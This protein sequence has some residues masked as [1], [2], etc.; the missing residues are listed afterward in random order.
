MTRFPVSCATNKIEQILRRD[1]IYLIKIV[2]Y[3]QIIYS[4]LQLV[5]ERDFH[6]SLIGFFPLLKQ[7][8]ELP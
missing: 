8:I 2:F 5:K 4:Y 1:C 7:T 3:H 6:E